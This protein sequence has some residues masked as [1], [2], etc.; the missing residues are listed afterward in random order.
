[1]SR[2]ARVLGCAVLVICLA[3]CAPKEYTGQIFAMDTFMQMSVYGDGAEV[4]GQ[5]ALQS[6]QSR[7]YELEAAL[8][9]TR[10]GSDV[11]KINQSCGQTVTVS[12]D[13]AAVLARTLEL[14]EETCGVLDI[15]AYP[16]VQAWGFTTGEYRVPGQ[17]ELTVL[18]EHIDYAQMKMDGT[19]VTLPEGMQI[20]LGA[21]AKG[22]TGDVLAA[23]LREMGVEKACL[24]LGGNIHTLGSNPEGKPW[25]VGIQH[26]VTGGALAVVEVT[27]KAVVTSG[28]YQR[29]FEENGE[30]YWHI[31]DPETAAPA[32]SGLVSVSVIGEEGTR[33]DALSTALFVMGL[34][35]AGQFWREHRDF[36]AVFVTE[37]EEIYIT[38]GLKDSFSLLEP[39]QK[40]EVRVIE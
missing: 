26:P 24:S 27:D 21:V 6:I 17:E 5:E 20:D 3:G 28:N 10:E 12:E 16:A 11:H 37:E 1:M 40:L 13:T 14:C 38:G 4:T 23:Q 33:C 36:E 30:T 29:Y 2:W 25:R 19:G 18:A 32:R 31:L 34:E 35:E 22:Y 7:V 9:V 15:T 39:F 8:S